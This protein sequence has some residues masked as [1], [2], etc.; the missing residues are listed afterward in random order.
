MDDL[1]IR[2]ISDGDVDTLL[3]LKASVHALHVAARPDV[4]KPMSSAELGRWL[5]DRLAEDDTSGWLAERGGTRLGYVLAAHR[6]RPETSFSHARQWLEIDEVVVEPSERRRGVARALIERVA[7][8]GETLGLDGV[9]LTAWAFND[10]AHA[11]F[12]RA[13]FRPMT[14]RYERPGSTRR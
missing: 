3:T 12:E 1:A 14:L 5:R 2:S 4:F 11:A 7:A 8:E 6:S 10:T 9:E 13:G